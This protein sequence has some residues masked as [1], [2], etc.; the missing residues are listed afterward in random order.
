MRISK[1]KK[2]KKLLIHTLILLSIT[3]THVSALNADELND[4]LTKNDI[5]QA[6]DNIVLILKNNY[7][8]P[9]KALLVGQVL[10]HK[11]ATN[12]LDE[13]SDWYSLIRTLNLIIRNTSGDMYLDIV[14]ANPLFVIRKSK[15]NNKLENRD[16]FGINRVSILSGNVGYMKINYFYQNPKAETAIFCAL[17]TLSKVDA[18]IIDLRGVEGESISLAQYL[19][20]FF[21]EKNIILSEVLYD[22]QNKTKILRALENN[23]NAKFKHNFP[24]YVL[25]SSFTSSSGEFVSYTLKHLGKAV[26]VGE[27]TLG[28]AYV[29]QNQDINGVIS[30]SI[31]IGIH[32][33][34]ITNANWGEIGVIPDLN[35]AANL[36]SKEAHKM[37]KR[38]L[39]IF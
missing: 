35:I 38:Y 39:G 17:K 6:I 36:S 32:L 1:F 4:T 26:I 29:L 5:N 28:V 15:N 23:G 37:A 7:V 3:I 2:I 12:E 24:V 11:I 18:L 27:E 9:E 13:I 19:M 16:D 21:V 8:F 14:E 31:P 20:S 25:T 22:K 34:P 30:L 10:R 33:N